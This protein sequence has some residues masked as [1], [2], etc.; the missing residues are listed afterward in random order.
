[1]E[2]VAAKLTSIM[3]ST[4]PQ[5]LCLHDLVLSFFLRFLLVLPKLP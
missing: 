2:D 3:A 5:F 4:T 1:M